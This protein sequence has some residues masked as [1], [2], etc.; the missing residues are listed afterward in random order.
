MNSFMVCTKIALVIKS[1]RKR[2]AVRVARTWGQGNP[3]GFL[4]WNP[5][6]KKP[7]EIHGR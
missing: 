4:V 6:G 3:Y 1:R 2:W 7:L 5:K